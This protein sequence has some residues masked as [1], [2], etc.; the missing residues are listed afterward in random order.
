M[1]RSEDIGELAAALAKAQGE[2]PAVAKTKT[3]PFFHSTYADLADVVKVIGPVLA[4]HGL[5]Y[6]QHVET[7]GQDAVLTTTLMHSSGQHVSSTAPL[8]VGKH[9]PQ[10]LASAVTYGRRMALTAAVGCVADSDDD[11]N[12]ASNATHDMPATRSTGTQPKSQ[13]AKS[14]KEATEAQWKVIIRLS[15]ELLQEVPKGDLTVTEASALIDKLQDMKKGSA[16]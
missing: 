5:A 6:T 3:N 16:A 13:A 2:M 15:D 14:A 12:A 9:D 8:Y 11:G 4:K 7:A 1:R 10:G